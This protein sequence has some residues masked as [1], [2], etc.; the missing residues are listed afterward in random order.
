[1]LIDADV[2]P[3]V[4]SIV[5]DSAAAGEGDEL[6]PR[7]ADH[8]GD[9][10]P[11]LPARS[12]ARGETRVVVERAP[13]ASASV[14]RAVLVLVAVSL[15]AN[16]ALL[17]FTWRTGSSI[18]DGLSDVG[19]ALAGT[20]HE[21]RIEAAPPADPAPPEPRRPIEPLET[22][23]GSIETPERVQVRVAEEELAAGEPAAARRRLYRLLAVIDGMT[24]P[25]RDEL[26]AQATYLVAESYRRQARALREVAR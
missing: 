12:G 16:L 4:R 5:E 11:A 26:E 3:E 23:P 10:D 24:G 15:V 20:F 25:E 18:R 22:V 7:H 6:T 14:P 9:V 17:A 1:M 8:E 19:Q 2:D 21:V 13:A